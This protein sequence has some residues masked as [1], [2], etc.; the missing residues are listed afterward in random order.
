M[1][2]VRNLDE[3]GHW[4]CSM[5][6]CVR[7]LSNRRSML[8]A[9]TKLNGMERG[10]GSVK[11]RGDMGDRRFCCCGGRLTRSS[12][13]YELTTIHERQPLRSSDGKAKPVTKSVG[14]R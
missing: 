4:I 11:E 8:F 14:H 2:D 7:V 12:S 9:T 5:I 10:G 1:A 3:L 6:R 13:S